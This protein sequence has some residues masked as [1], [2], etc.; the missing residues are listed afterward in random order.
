MSIKTGSPRVKWGLAC[1]ARLFL[2]CRRPVRRR[3]PPHG[4]R[5]VHVTPVHMTI[6]RGHVSTATGRGSCRGEPRHQ[7]IPYTPLRARGPSPTPPLWPRPVYRRRDLHRRSSSVYTMYTFPLTFPSRGCT[8]KS[9]V[10]RVHRVHHQVHHR[11][12]GGRSAGGM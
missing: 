6:L 5:S 4:K 10:L 2:Y 3:H 7:F 9:L 1:E 8:A 11:S 12:A